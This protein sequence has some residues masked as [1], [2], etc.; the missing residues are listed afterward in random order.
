MAKIFFIF[1][2]FVLQHVNAAPIVEANAVGRRESIVVDHDYA[3]GN[4]T[5]PAGYEVDVCFRKPVLQLKPYL[6]LLQIDLRNTSR[7][8][9]NFCAGTIDSGNKAYVCG[10]ARLGP[11]ILPSCLPL[12]FLIG[13]TTYSRF[14]G[15][16][17]GEFLST[18]TNYAPPGKAGWFLY[19]FSDGFANNTAGL[20]IR[21]RITLKPGVKVDRFGGV[22]GNFVAPA[23]SPYDQRALPPANLDF[24]AGDAS[25]VPYNYHVYE[26]EKPL[27]AVA[28]PVAPWFGQPGLGTQFQLPASI[29][30]LLKNG[31]LKEV[32]VEQK[33]NVRGS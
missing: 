12:T 29:A 17:P 33:C 8:D 3:I 25:Q 10:D 22:T 14:G 24:D 13:S 7:C 4:N 21:G 6:T 2:A 27:V 19:P 31:T 23:G 1:A 11:V 9:T 20:P 18:W 15:L 26:V 28:G 5:K 16:C 30:E 32:F